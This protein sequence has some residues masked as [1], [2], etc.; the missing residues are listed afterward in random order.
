MAAAT[1]VTVVGAHPL[2]ALAHCDLDDL[3]SE[4]IAVAPFGRLS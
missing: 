2:A 3:Y 1:L 4:I